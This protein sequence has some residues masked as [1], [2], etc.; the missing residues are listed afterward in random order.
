M[1]LSELDLV[2]KLF[3]SVFIVRDQP[4]QDSKTYIYVQLLKCRV[5]NYFLHHHHFFPDKQKVI[6]R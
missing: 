4:E 2:T 5:Y 3:L 1:W 6:S